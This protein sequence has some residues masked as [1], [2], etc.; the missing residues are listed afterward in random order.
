MKKLRRVLEIDKVDWLLY[1]DRDIMDAYPDSHN[2]EPQQKL[3]QER[4]KENLQED[5]Y[6]LEYIEDKTYAFT[7]IGRVFGGY[8]KKEIALTSTESD[9]FVQLKNKR[10]KYSE[11]YDDFEYNHFAE[12]LLK[13]GTKITKVNA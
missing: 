2:S 8:K 9:I 1:N 5:E 10:Y 3:L 12:R 13:L 7:N 4:L 6:V 11:M